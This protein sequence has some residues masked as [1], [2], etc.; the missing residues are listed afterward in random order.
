MAVEPRHGDGEHVV[1]EREEDGDAEVGAGLAAGDFDAEGHADQ[2]E[3]EDGEGGVEFF[4]HGEGHLHHGAG[5]VF[6]GVR[7][8]GER[9]DAGF[10]GA[11]FGVGHPR[12]FLPHGGRAKEAGE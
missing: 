12:E 1:A 11:E 2:R 3:G 7:I 9:G 10:L 6:R 4:L 5:V 8:D